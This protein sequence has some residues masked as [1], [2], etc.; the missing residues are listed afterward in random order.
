MI[1]PDGKLA[2]TISGP[3]I[4]GPWDAA[5]SDNGAT[6][7]LFVANTLVGISRASNHTTDNDQGDVV[8][9]TLA[10]SA[11]VPPKL[12]GQTVIMRRIGEPI[13]SDTSLLTDLRRA[14]FRRNAPVAVSQA[15]G[16]VRIGTGQQAAELDHAT[17]AHVF[18]TTA[19]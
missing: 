8:R 12:T 2:D 6:A 11:T 17:A 5:V 18:V 1:S 10:E 19:V 16:R 14:G 9:L 4:D 3:N 15:N 13:Q 7:T